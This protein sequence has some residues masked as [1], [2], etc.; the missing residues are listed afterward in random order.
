HGNGN[1]RLAFSKDG[2]RVFTG[3]ADS[4]VRIWDVGQGADNEPD[5]AAEA[6]GPITWIE[7]A[8]DCWLSSSEDSEVRRYAK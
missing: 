5:T 2:S 3:G 4:L 8:E 1:T 7:A 6:E